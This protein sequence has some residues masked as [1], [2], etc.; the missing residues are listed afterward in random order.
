MRKCKMVQPKTVFIAVALTLVIGAAIACGVHSF[1]FAKQG[2]VRENV[3][4][5]FW[6]RQNK[7]VKQCVTAEKDGFYLLSE[8]GKKRRFVVKGVE[9]ASGIAGYADSDYK[10]SKKTWLRWFSQIQEMGANTIRIQ[11]IYNDTFYRAFYEYNAKR[12]NPLYL[13]QGIRVTEYAGNCAK[14]AYHKSFYHVLM[15]DTKRAVDVIHGKKKIALNKETGSGIYRK[16]VSK[17]VLGYIVGAQWNA[18]TIAYTNEQERDRKAYCGSYFS[19][20]EEAT[21]FETLLAKVMDEMV[22][23]ETGKYQEQR[24]LAFINSPE[25]DPFAYDTYYAKQLGKYVSLDAEHVKVKANSFGGYFAAYQLEEFCPEYQKYFSA[26]QKKKLS[27]LLT[28]GEE[29]GYYESYTRL[30]C[31]YHQIP[32]LALTYGFSTARGVSQ[33]NGKT[34]LPLNETMQGERIV[35]TYQDVM[36]AGCAGA[37]ITSWQDSW[38]RLSWNMAY[39]MDLSGVGRWHDRQTVTQNYGVLSFD[40]GKKK[41]ICYVDGGT[42]DW[43]HGKPVARCGKNA[44][45]V[46]YD[47]ENVYFMVRGEGVTK[48]TRLYLPVD[49]LSGQGADSYGSCSFSRQADFL[50]LLNGE[51]DSKLLVHS[52][53]DGVRQNF[54]EM[55]NGQNPFAEYAKKDAPDF[56]PVSM[57]YHRKK[58]AAKNASEEEKRRLS[59]FGIWDSAFLRHGNANPSSAQYD[60]LADYCYGKNCVEIRIPWSMLQ[61]SNPLEGTFHADYYVNYGKQDQRI[62]AIY[63]GIGCGKQGTTVK[64]GQVKRF[65]KKTRAAYHERTKQ[66]Y[67][68]IK[69]S[70]SD[71]KCN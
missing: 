9:L 53:Y 44:L 63:A 52:R 17:W 49:I 43:E 61:C 70:W 7:S 66:S 59:Y 37:V 69:K 54:L 15:R 13:M 36:R 33:E 22:S 41:S 21:A 46:Q 38:N 32:V 51:T 45:F 67:E 64:M 71:R 25:T 3:S 10:I 20:G 39:R 28:Q 57:V 11:T 40:P 8:D 48:Q 6:M 27:G 55:I 24:L 1:C 2:K 19:T 47:E 26:E 30:L 29:N 50:L 14:D 23:Y 60:S 4:N 68:I 62:R 35:S 18:G 58:V 65:H 5:C 56:V 31:H 42:K 16:D 34:V 12:K